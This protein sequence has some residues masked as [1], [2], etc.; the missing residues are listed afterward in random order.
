M[1][2]GQ[3]RRCR[4]GQGADVS[5]SSGPRVG[6]GVASVGEGDGSGPVGSGSGSGSGSGG[7]EETTIATVLP[8]ATVA[9]EPGS[10]D[11]T[12]PAAAEF[13]VVVTLT[14]SW[15]FES[16]ASTSA[17]DLPTSPPG[18][19]T[20]DG[21]GLDGPGFDGPGFDGSGV[22]GAGGFGVVGAGGC[23]AAGVV[24]FGAG[25]LGPAGFCGV[26]GALLSAGV[27]RVGIFPAAKNSKCHGSGLDPLGR[28]HAGLSQ[29]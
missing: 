20:V 5:V 4:A 1:P 3:A 2:A 22:V 23:G 6:V 15:A 10:T 25:A 13:S 21:S 7:P 29:P 24:G 26:D 17:C 12:V 28:A 14:L 19:V 8:T 18:T 11:S 27:Y 16:A 9:P